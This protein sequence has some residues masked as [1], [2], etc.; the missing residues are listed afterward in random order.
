MPSM[1]WRYRLRPSADQASRAGC[2]LMSFFSK[3]AIVDGAENVSFVTS[4]GSCAVIT[5]GK[6]MRN[7]DEPGCGCAVAWSS[8]A[9]PLELLEPGLEFR[10]A[11]QGG[12]PGP[13]RLERERAS[14]IF[15]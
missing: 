13:Q 10:R 2:P 4:T 9:D 15:R 12:E 1:D 11:G 6:A 8:S 7:G 5:A 14:E 3:V